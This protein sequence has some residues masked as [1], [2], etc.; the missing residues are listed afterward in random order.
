[1]SAETTGGVAK[2][3]ATFGAAA[4]FLAATQ[5]TISSRSASAPSSQKTSMRSKRDGGLGGGDVPAF[6]ERV[7]PR[8]HVFLARKGSAG[9]SLGEALL[10]DRDLELIRRKG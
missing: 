8:R 10:D 7:E 5:S 6:K 9:I 2:G 3:A 4:G 1:V